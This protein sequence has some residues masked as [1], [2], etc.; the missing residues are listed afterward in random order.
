M[1][2]D[3]EELVKA[4]VGEVFSTMLA[5]QIEPEPPNSPVVNGDATIAGSVGFIGNLTGIVYLYL[6]QGFAVRLTEKL[7][8]ISPQSVESE[9]LVND[10]VGELT[11]MVVGHLKSRLSDRGRSCVMTIPSIVRGTNFCIEP[12]SSTIRRLLTFRSHEHQVVVEILM[13]PDTSS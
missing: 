5:Q 12:V 3:L 10:S 8:G 4:A 1:I 2:D 11:N 6:P 9:E 13:R 7:L